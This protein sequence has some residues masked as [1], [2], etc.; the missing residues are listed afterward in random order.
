MP[1]Y[2]GV[3]VAILLWTILAIHF[4]FEIAWRAKQSFAEVLGSLAMCH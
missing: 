2:V 3:V 1:V 4:F